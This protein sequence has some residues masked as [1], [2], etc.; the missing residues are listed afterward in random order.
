M[1]LSL[2]SPS[3]DKNYELLDSGN[4]QKLERF[5][6]FILSRPEPQA[7][8]HPSMAD[9][10]WERLADAVFVK[11]QNSEEKGQWNLK[12]RMKEQWWI[13]YKPLGLHFRLGLTAFKHVGIFPEQ[14]ANWDFIAQKCTEYN[15]PKV[16]NLF[17][18][19]GGATMAAAHGGAMVTH[20][21]SVKQTVSWARENMERSG[22][23]S[24]RWIV[25]DAMKFVNR[26]VRRESKYEGIILD[27]PSYGRGADGE[28]WVLNENILQMLTQC[29]ELLADGGF[30]VLNLY[31]MGL[32]ATLAN[33]LINSVF[34]E[35]A[36]ER[37]EL[38]VEDSYGKKL[39]LGV[40]LRF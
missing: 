26:E 13:E 2:L 15:N 38:F 36:K 1:Q 21:D 22:L 27:P 34:G 25:E 8:W 3:W 4:G 16:L 7:L 20:V 12:P 6:S 19:T 33:T 10:E 29:K 18:Y 14:A 40:F 39:P 5:G 11:S 24:A 32:S 37:G 17:A 30:L 35:V 31:S 9:A 23:G 28:K